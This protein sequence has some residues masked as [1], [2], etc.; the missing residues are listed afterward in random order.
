ME[1][2]KEGSILFDVIENIVSTANDICNIALLILT[3]WDI[4]K[5]KRSNRH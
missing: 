5:N 4:L 2:A 1:Y 3:V